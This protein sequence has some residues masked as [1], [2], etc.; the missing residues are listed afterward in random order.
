MLYL[1]GWGSLGSVGSVGRR[2]A[3]KIITNQLIIVKPKTFNLGNY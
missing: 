3:G 1:M 2:K